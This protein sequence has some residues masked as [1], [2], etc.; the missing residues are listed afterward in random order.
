MGLLLKLLLGATTKSSKNQSKD[1]K[2]EKLEREMKRYGLL[3]EEKKLVRSGE[4]DSWN[5][6]EEEMDEDDYYHDDT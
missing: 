2:N 6:E 5:F 4:Y 1:K 3:E